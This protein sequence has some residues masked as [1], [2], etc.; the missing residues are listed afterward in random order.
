MSKNKTSNK[1]SGRGKLV[2]FAVVFML[3]IAPAV[4]YLYLKKG[5]DYRL[6]SIEQLKEKPISSELRAYI[7]KNN[8]FT[9]NARLL[10]FPKG[11]IAE[12]LKILNIID[13]RIVDRTRFDIVS[14]AEEPAGENKDQ[15]DFL[16][17]SAPAMTSQ[18]YQFLLLDT[19]NL[20]RAV[21]PLGPD[22]GKEIMRHLSV[23][24]PVPTKREITLRRDSL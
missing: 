15:I 5:F 7:E 9:G 17:A 24:I 8:P 22:V 12:E 6:E 14:F 21:Y 4:S 19:A 23:I 3:I 2:G 10:H 11:E 18:E 13:E 16:G 20:V 1:V